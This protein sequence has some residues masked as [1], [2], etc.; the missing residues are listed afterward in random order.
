[1]SQYVQEKSEKTDLKELIKS[2]YIYEFLG[3]KDKDIVEEADLEE[4]LINHLEEFMLELGNGFCFESRQKRIL[5]DDDYFFCDLVFYHRILKCHVLIDLKAA[6]IKYDEI[7]IFRITGATSC[8]K[9][10][11]RLW[12][13]LCVRRQEKNL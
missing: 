12:E 8:K 10:T 7:C 3:L 11:I 1:M 6:K 9:T 4:A 13:F 2:P 5:V